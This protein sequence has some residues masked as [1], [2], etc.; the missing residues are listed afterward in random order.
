VTADH[1]KGLRQIVIDH[2]EIKSRIVVSL[3]QRPR[4]TDDGID[5]MPVAVFVRALANGEIFRGASR[6]RS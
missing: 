4:R 3:E 1:L 5:V 6:P 2:P